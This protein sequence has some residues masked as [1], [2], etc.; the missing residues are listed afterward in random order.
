MMF[1]ERHEIAPEL[2]K[3]GTPYLVIGRTKVQRDLA[4]ILRRGTGVCSR[5]VIAHAQRIY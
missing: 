1:F 5:D 3:N 4:S 2:K